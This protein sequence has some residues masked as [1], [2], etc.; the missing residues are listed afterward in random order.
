M[1]GALAAGAMVFSEVFPALN[2]LI[3][4][5]AVGAVL[6]NTVGIPRWAADGVARHKVLLETGIVLLGARMALDELLGTGPTI[7]LVAAGIVVFGVLYVELLA[8][9]V[10]GLEAGVRSVLAA[11]ASV[12]GVSAVLAVA[13]SVDADETDIS[14]AVATILFFDAITLVVFPLLAVP[15]GLPDKAFGV[16]AGLSLFSTGPTA[17]VGF[18]ISDVAGE[19]ATVTK[20]VRN[21]FIGVLAIGY[22]VLAATDREE[23]VAVSAV[24]YQF[25]KFLV[26]FVLLAIVANVGV[27]TSPMVDSIETVGGWLFALAF[28]GL[29]FEIDLSQL[30]TVG[31]TPVALVTVHLVTLSSLA[32]L[33]VVTLL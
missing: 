31:F 12:C 1:L 13:G 2:P 29:G 14:Y 11:G 20:L 21:S 5:I 24:W 33:A 26:G 8:R 4:A 19:W 17:A 28:V 9:Y 18:A 10:F 22:G 27:L 15:L 25:P 32:F 3:L 6:G 30:R 23:G 7:V 16:W